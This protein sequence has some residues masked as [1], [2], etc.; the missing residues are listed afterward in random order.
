MANKEILL[1]VDVF[2]NEKEIEKE[3]V[4]QAIESALETATIKRHTNQ[5]KARVV[6]D[7][8]TGDYITYRLWDVVAPN[9]EVNGEVEFPGHQI[10]LEAARL[11]NPDAQVG[12]VVEEEIESVEFGRIAAQTAKQVIIHRVP[13]PRRRVDHWYRQTDGKRQCLS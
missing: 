13:G 5:I 4:F 11:D 12:D 3:V 6:I 8:K 10:T 2:S 9:D 7:R 1:V